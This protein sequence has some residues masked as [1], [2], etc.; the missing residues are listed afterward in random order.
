MNTAGESSRR[1]FWHA[2]HD[3][4]A[5]YVGIILH[6]GRFWAKS[7]SGSVR[8]CCFTSCWTVLSH[9]M[10][11]QPSC[12]LQS[13]GGEAN[14]IFLASALLSMRIICPNRVSRRDW[15]IAV[16]LGCFV[17]Y[18]IVWFNV[19]LY[20]LNAI[21]D[22]TIPASHWTGTGKTNMTTTKPSGTKKN[23]TISESY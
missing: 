19:P 23:W 22:T 1:R 11:G 12:L 3:C 9:V 7:A 18:G 14:R 13:A 15:I 8:W 2:T 6:R 21:L 17:R 16:S 20:T 4:I 5:P 10:R